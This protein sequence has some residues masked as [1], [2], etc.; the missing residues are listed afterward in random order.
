MQYISMFLK[1]EMNAI[2][3]LKMKKKRVVKEK[4][5][6]NYIRECFK[7]VTEKNQKNILAYSFISE[8]T[9]AS[10]LFR[11]KNSIL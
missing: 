1:Q 4:Y 10:F 8:H 2:N 11:E 9:Y 7:S 5:F 3:D 6:Y